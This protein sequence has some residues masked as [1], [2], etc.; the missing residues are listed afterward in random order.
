MGSPQTTHP[1]LLPHIIEAMAQLD[2]ALKGLSLLY[3]VSEWVSVGQEVNNLS[4]AIATEIYRGDIYLW[5]VGRIT[6][7]NVFMGGRKTVKG[8]GGG[9]L[10]RTRG[11]K[12]ICLTIWNRQRTDRKDDDD[13]EEKRKGKLPIQPFANYWFSVFTP[14]NQWT[15]NL[16]LLTL[17]HRFSNHPHVDGVVALDK[18]V[19]PNPSANFCNYWNV[20]FI[21]PFTHRFLSSS[22][23]LWGEQEYQ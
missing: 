6:L 16:N 11:M 20:A 12:L 15:T 7:L 10:R 17:V 8:R 21:L 9:P 14:P 19:E 2:V 22:F 23:V 5:F 3:V 4:L 18:H 1:L 13:G